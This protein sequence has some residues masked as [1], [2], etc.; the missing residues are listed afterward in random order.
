MENENELVPIKIHNVCITETTKGIAPVVVLKT[1]EDR[2]IKVY[3][4][5]SEAI[6]IDKGHRGEQF[7][8]PYSHDLMMNLLDKVGADA[9]KAVIDELEGGVFFAQLTLSQEGGGDIK[10]DARP[11][12]CMALSTRC[13]TKLYMKPKIIKEV[14]KDKEEIEDLQ[15]F[16]DYL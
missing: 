10:I 6:S 12:D 13:E 16:K 5:L 8:R 15:L 9:K 14:G 2:Y 1:E 11:S 7:K 4:G 3:V